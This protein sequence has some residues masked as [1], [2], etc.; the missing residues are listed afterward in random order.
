M[1]KSK[2]NRNLRF[3]VLRSYTV[4]QFHFLSAKFFDE[5]SEQSSSV[6]F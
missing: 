6:I 5:R 1:L 3:T 2:E 4:T